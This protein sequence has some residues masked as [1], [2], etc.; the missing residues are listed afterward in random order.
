MAD[1]L[2]HTA[3]DQALRA[4]ART[5][6]RR[7][8]H[9]RDAG[10]PERIRTRPK[11]PPLDKPKRFVHP[12]PGAFAADDFIL[13]LRWKPRAWWR[14]KRACYARGRFANAVIR[15]FAE[16]YALDYEKEHPYHDGI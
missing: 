2:I 1:K 10:K 11:F 8:T 5:R 12:M 14:F 13:A 4:Y 6:G 16:Q 3:I 15:E 9:L 7:R